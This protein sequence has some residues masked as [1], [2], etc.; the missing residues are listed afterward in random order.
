M[1]Q[2]RYFSDHSTLLQGNR[3]L[4]PLV[5]VYII[6]H[7]IVA[8]LTDVERILSLLASVYKMAQCRLILKSVVHNRTHKALRLVGR[9]F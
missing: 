1:L 5:L 3:R 2:S 9:L 6:D 8:N 4:L 7:A